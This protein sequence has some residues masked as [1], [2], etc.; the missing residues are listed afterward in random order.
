MIFITGGVGSGKRAFV[1]GHLGYAEQQL[2]TDPFDDR[3]VFCDLQ[4]LIR[5]RGDFDE[6]LKASLF[7]KQVVVCDEVGCGVVP[8]DKNERTWRDEVGMAASTVAAEADVVVR[9]V[10]GI[11]QIIK[12]TLT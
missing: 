10:C 1:L 3:P 7:K 11:P 2:S 8:L 12:G 9:M 5:E 4:D 6:A